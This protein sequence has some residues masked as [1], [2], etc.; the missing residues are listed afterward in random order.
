MTHS[1]T[2]TQID[3]LQSRLA[4]QDDALHV[5]S[6]QIAGQAEHLRLLQEHIRLLN[7]KLNELLSQGDAKSSAPVDER[8]PHY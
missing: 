6:E 8:P 4:F 7:Q 2:Q 1:T 5:M 3:E